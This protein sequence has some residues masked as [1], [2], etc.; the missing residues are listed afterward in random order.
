MSK[1]RPTLLIT[2]GAGFIGANFVVHM[3]NTYPDYHILNL[4][5]LTYAGTLENVKEVENRPNYSFVE[6]DIADS[7]LVKSLFNEHNITGVVHFAAESHVDRSIE[8]GTSFVTTNVLGTYTLLEAAKEA[9]GK[10]DLLSENRFHHISTDEVYGSLGNDG[11]F[12]EE[13]PYDPRNP[14]SA[15]KAGANM[16]VKSFGFT[17][18]MNIVIS[19]CSNNYGPKQHQEKLIPTIISNALAEK[20]IPIY[21][22]GEN[23][24]DWIY[25]EDHCNALDTIFH[26][27]KVMES[28]NVGGRTEKTNI[29]VAMKICDILDRMKDDLDISSNIGSFKDLITFTKDRLGHD[30]RY[31]VDDTKIR[32]QL[33]WAPEIS[34]DEGLKKTVDWYVDQWTKVAP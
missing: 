14:Y 23:I 32:E 16:L 33:G 4:D 34:F 21:G 27:G 8:D 22:D 19:S 11:M 28:Y 6:G 13:T 5:K 31:A 20:P 15:T 12:S 2:G 10:A 18:G 24:R 30:R 7:I 9:W 1:Q 25:V 26:K 3:V 17:Y 29:D